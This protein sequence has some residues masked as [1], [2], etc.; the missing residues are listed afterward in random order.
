[1]TALA[2]EV[3]WT[4]GYFHD[5]EE[6][7]LWISM[8]APARRAL[9]VLEAKPITPASI[10]ELYALR[11][12]PMLDNDAF[13][14]AGLMMRAR[15]W[16]DAQVM[17]AQSD[18]SGRLGKDQ[19]MVAQ[20]LSLY[21]HVN[22]GS[23]LGELILVEQVATTL[24]AT[25]EALERGDITIWHVKALAKQTKRCTPRVAKYV[26]ER[27]IP[28]AVEKEWTPG[29]LARAAAKAVIAAD[30]DGAA[31]RAAEAKKNSDVQLYGEAN[32]MAT[33]SS[34]GPA[35]TLKQ[36][37]DAL[38]ARAR[39]LKEAGDPRNLGQLR[40]QALSDAVL[41]GDTASWPRVR[42]D[43]TVDLT[44]Y[45]GLTR[46]PGE[47]AGYGPITAE[48]AREVSQDAQLRRLLTDP[49]EGTVIDVGRRRYR[50][51]KR[52]HDIVKAVHPICSMPGCVRPSIDCDEDHRIDW[53]EGG[54]TSTCS[55]HP[56]CRR[57]HNLKTNKYWR[58]DINPDGSEVWT[59]PLGFSYR[60]RSPSYPID[61]IE[62][63]EDDIPEQ[64]AYRLP[65][66]D[67]D[68]P[69]AIDGDGIPL[70][71][72]PALNDEEL[73]EFEYQLDLLTAFGSNFIDYANA[74]YDEAR[75]IGLIA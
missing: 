26:E 44:T 36:V 53:A 49:V 71:D 56:L 35:V 19:S 6:R 21:A 16:W 70:P 65:D 68:P 54:C 1:M 74:H 22:F 31:D 51:T 18:C 48:T 8:C 60:K 58:V 47:L 61:L 63:V 62:P 23:M 57:H 12:A 30:P 41:G 45:L 14:Y 3:P 32:E 52:Q 66:T 2:T 72:P 27:L 24:G 33:L 73:L 55:L 10:A 25:W 67:P 20:E 40:I 39:Q 42:A 4:W 7:A 64:I 38:D 69:W 5:S 59:S 15:S 29:E 46:H 43:V 9:E 37:R 75:A 13:R 17:V 34:Y 28:L 11:G 50:P